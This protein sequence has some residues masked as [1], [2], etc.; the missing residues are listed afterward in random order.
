MEEQSLGSQLNGKPR[1]Q[2]SEE[3]KF[4]L[5]EG[6]DVIPDFSVSCLQITWT[7]QNYL[8][9]IM[10]E[11]SWKIYKITGAIQRMILLVKLTVIF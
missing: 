5:E 6:W 3:N 7:V 9:K 10:L 1:N 2:F 4:E 11:E 8:N